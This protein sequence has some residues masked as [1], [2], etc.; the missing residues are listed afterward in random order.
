MCSGNSLHQHKMGGCSLIRVCS[1]IRSNTV[2][3]FDFSYYFLQYSWSW[4]GFVNGF[5]L[6]STGIDGR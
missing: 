3:A 4:N 5:V 2:F 6:T 1:L